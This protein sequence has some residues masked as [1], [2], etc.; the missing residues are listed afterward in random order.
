MWQICACMCTCNT[1]TYMIWNNL[2]KSGNSGN[3]KKKQI[4]GNIQIAG[5]KGNGI[6]QA[7][8]QQQ[9]GN[10]TTQVRRRSPKTLPDRPEPWSSHRSHLILDLDFPANHGNWESAHTAVN[11]SSQIQ[12]EQIWSW[13]SLLEREGKWLVYV[14]FH[15][16]PQEALALGLCSIKGV[17]TWF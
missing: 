6:V 5:G 16:S 1:H 4:R 8:L 13:P 2:F 11:H 12:R 7:A 3:W 10:K 15:H 14:P 9:L 17:V